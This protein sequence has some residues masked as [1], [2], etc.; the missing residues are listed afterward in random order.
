MEMEMETEEE[1]EK[2]GEHGIG[3]IGETRARSASLR[4]CYNELRVTPQENLEHPI[5]LAEA[6]SNA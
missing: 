3:I 1:E 5:L 6:R 4:A 2:G